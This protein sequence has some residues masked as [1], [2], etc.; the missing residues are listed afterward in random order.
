MRNTCRRRTQSET[1]RKQEEIQSIETDLEVTQMRGFPGSPVVKSLPGN[2]PHSKGISLTLISK[3]R[4]NCDNSMR[5]FYGYE[6]NAMGGKENICFIFRLE[7]NF[8]EKAMCNL[9]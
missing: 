5:G 8:I 6:E 7:E 3:Y 1:A 9:E 4:I 2:S